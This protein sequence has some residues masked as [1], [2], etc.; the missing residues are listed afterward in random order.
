M[1]LDYTR[2]LYP[3]GGEH[4]GK[5]PTHLSCQNKVFVP[6]PISVTTAIEKKACRTEFSWNGSEAQGLFGSVF[7]SPRFVSYTTQ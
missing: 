4:L 7:L 1:D 5:E 6:S 2:A 3:S